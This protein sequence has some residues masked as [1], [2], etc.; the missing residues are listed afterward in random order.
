MKTYEAAEL[1]LIR[2]LTEDIV[3]SSPDVEDGE[4]TGDG[5]IGE[6]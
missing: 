4:P 1:E 5:D 6:P 3:T 2:F